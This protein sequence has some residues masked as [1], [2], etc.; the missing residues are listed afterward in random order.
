MAVVVVLCVCVGWRWEAKQVGLFAGCA[1]LIALRSLVLFYL[2]AFLPAPW[3]CYDSNNKYYNPQNTHAPKKAG[4]DR[5]TKLTQ[6]EHKKKSMHVD[7]SFCSAE[8]MIFFPFLSSPHAT[9][10]PPHSPPFP[11]KI[12]IPSSPQLQC[13]LSLSLSNYTL[14]FDIYAMLPLSLPT[15]TPTPTLTLA[16][17]LLL[18]LR[19]SG[20]LIP[21]LPVT[22]VTVNERQKHTHSH[23]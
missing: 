17:I 14:H 22:F 11:T 6:N 4:G 19:C 2:S 23:T 8:H 18:L 3:K 5:E 20:P 10:Y 13:A 1:A 16:Y 9:P 7:I 15:F 12:V 21:L